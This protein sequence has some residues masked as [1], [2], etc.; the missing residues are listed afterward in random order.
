M[1]LPALG[2]QE[3][4]IVLNIFCCTKSYSIQN[5]SNAKIGT[6]RCIHMM[7]S[8]QNVRWAC[9]CNTSI[10]IMKY[11]TVL[12]FGIGDGTGFGVDVL[13]PQPECVS[14]PPLVAS[15][16]KPN[17]NLLPP[18]KKKKRKGIP[19]QGWK[20]CCIASRSEETTS[21]KAQ[22]PKSGILCQQDSCALL[23][24]L[25]ASSLCFLSGVP[26]TLQLQKGFSQWRVTSGSPGREN[27]EEKIT[28]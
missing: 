7:W 22:Q 4:G 19:L 8:E 28:F 16:K 6:S 25:V 11:A 2:D 14:Q 20:R 5:I 24:L 21:A 9:E 26:V 18:P 13:E 1:V 12:D 27:L 10:F 3:P 17:S 15:N 23:L